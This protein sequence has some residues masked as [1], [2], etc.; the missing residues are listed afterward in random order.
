MA[1]GLSVCVAGVLAMILVYVSWRMAGKRADRIEAAAAAMDRQADMI[2]PY[3]HESWQA[4]YVAEQRG[5]HHKP[6][7]DPDAAARWR[8]PG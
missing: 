1:A 5:R 7:A 8:S 3:G 2:W 4:K 6:P